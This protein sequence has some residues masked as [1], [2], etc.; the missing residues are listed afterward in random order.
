MGSFGGFRQHFLEVSGKQP[1]PGGK[2]QLGRTPN[3][4]RFPRLTTRNIW[5]ATSA[6][7]P[8]PAPK[9]ESGPRGPAS[10]SARIVPAAMCAEAS[11]RREP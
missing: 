4:A 3:A 8:L 11:A 10:G 2:P 6:F 7:S 1:R 5:I 9:T